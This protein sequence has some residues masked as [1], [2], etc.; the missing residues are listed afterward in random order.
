MKI[1]LVCPYNIN[2]HG[3][4][5]EVVL[6]LKD[7]LQKRGHEI[8]IL[9][10]QLRNNS[11]PDHPDVIFVG[12]STDIYSP[13]KTTAQVS[14]TAD[15]D[16]IDEILKAENFDILH[17]HEPWVPFLSRQ[18]LQ[19]SNS[20]NI[21]TFHAKIPEAL[22]TRTMIKAVN[23]YMKSV[24]K[25][26]DVLTAVSDSAAEYALGM[27]A[28]PITLIPNGIDLR[29]YK[30]KNISKDKPDQRTILYVGRLE[31]RKGVKYLLKA[32][33]AFSIE[34]PDVKLI[35]AGDGPE[36]QKLELLAEDL[37][38]KNIEF[39]GYI[40]DDLKLELLAE[41]DLFCSPAPY[42]ESF[43]IVL[44]ES[45]AT[46]TVAVAGNNSGY[47]DL[48][49]GVGAIS[50]IDPDDSVEF[51]RRLN[52]M[53]NETDIRNLWKKWAKSYVQQYDY[54]KIVDQYEDLYKYAL[55][56]HGHAKN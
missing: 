15:N 28:K 54:P 20:V 8:K 24:I 35:I 38:I 27:T 5:L 47:A 2:K 40:S 1:G 6:A 22:M 45:M 7:E 29:K 36:R 26:L 41:A 4:V 37:K 51:A 42:G 50:I 16:K 46:G 13:A 39:L 52:L 18:L 30:I 53:I 56:T 44:L 55:K 43:G 48:M 11:I 10:P 12:T 32:F 33:K 3:G 14:T 25:Y 9:T 23:P 21:A 34:N 19:R 49:S 31:K 17:F